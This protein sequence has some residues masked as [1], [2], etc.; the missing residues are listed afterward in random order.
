ML[1][2]EVNNENYL[3]FGKKIFED[4]H[5]YNNSVIIASCRIIKALIPA[6]YLKSNCAHIFG[7]QNAR[8]N[9]PELYDKILELRFFM[10]LSY[11]RIAQHTQLTV[12][13]IR[14]LERKALWQ[15]Y[16]F[17]NDFLL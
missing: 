3:Q 13:Q 7:L 2:S 8:N 9:L 6:I 16:K 17:S 5:E 15:L 4:A 1:Q 11:S 10:S 12:Y 14:T